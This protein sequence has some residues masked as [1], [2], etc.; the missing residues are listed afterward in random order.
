MNFIIKTFGI[1]WLTLEGVIGSLVFG[2]RCKISIYTALRRT[3]RHFSAENGAETV[4]TLSAELE[5]CVLSRKSCVT[6]CVVPQF[7]NRMVIITLDV[8]D[9]MLWAGFAMAQQSR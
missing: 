1:F 5:L 3:Q 8:A 9:K 6:N 4:V 2:S 7:D